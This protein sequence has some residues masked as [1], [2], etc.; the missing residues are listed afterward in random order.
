MDLTKEQRQTVTQ[1]VKEGAGLSE[2]QTRIKAEF[3]VSLTFLATRMLVAE[4]G[5]QVKDKPEP[6]K[7]APPATANG[8]PEEDDLDAMGDEVPPAGAPDGM[9]GGKVSVTSDRVVRAGAVASGDVTFS[10]GTRAKWLLDQMGR[11]ALDGA[12]PGYHPSAQD[13]QEFQNQLRSLLQAR[14]Y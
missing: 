9:I 7:P 12:K 1:W 4:L 6:K 8:L 5:A 3:G 14:G 13:I 10:D 2:V 11:L